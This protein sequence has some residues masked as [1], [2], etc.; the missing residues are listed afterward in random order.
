MNLLTTNGQSFRC[1]CPANRVVF[2]A[3][4]VDDRRVVNG[5]LWR[6]WTGSPWAENP[7]RC[8]PPTTCY[9]RFVRWRKGGVWDRLLEA[10]SEAYDVIVV[11]LCFS[12][13][14]GECK[15]RGN[16]PPDSEMISP[17]NSEK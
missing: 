6:F 1:C 5:I 16:P 9:N 4:R 8:G 13:G 15:F 11:G 2:P 3:S 12:H 7:E 10:V 14:W 17:P